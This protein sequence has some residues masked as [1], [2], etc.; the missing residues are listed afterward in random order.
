MARQKYATLFERL[1]ANTK[2]P[3]GQSEATGCWIWIGATTLSRRSKN[4]YPRINVRRGG[5]HCCLRA[6][7]VMCEIMLERP[8]TKE[9]EPDHL[10]H[11]TLC[12]NPDHL[13]P[14]HHLV[15]KSRIRRHEPEAN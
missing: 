3:D 10:C 11:N 6:H 12:I 13:D 2:I 15:N 9:E 1:V 4:R 14:V 8:L 5:K 7:R